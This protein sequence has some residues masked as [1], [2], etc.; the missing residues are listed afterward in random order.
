MY[1]ILLIAAL[2]FIGCETTKPLQ[3]DAVIE[4][5]NEPIVEEEEKVKI[6]IERYGTDGE[7]LSVKLND[8]TYYIL[9]SGF[10]EGMDE[11]KIK[12]LSLQAPLKISEESVKGNRG[13]VITY[14]DVKIFLA[15]NGNKVGLFEHQKNSWTIG[16][17]MDRSS[18]IEIKLSANSTGVISIRRSSISLSYR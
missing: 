11:E 16:D 18:K 14:Y 9:G 4:P 13:I 10:A 7:V 8:K 3:K 12:N 6:K 17:D 2:F 5:N 15:D 1:K